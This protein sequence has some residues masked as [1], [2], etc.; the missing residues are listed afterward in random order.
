MTEDE[1]ARAFTEKRMVQRMPLEPGAKYDPGALVEANV[2]MPIHGDPV[3]IT[4]GNRK[5]FTVLGSK[6]PL[7]TL[8][9]Q[10]RPDC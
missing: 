6:A 10:E 4:P 5:E 2:F 3:C 1:Q 8:A 7:I 9:R